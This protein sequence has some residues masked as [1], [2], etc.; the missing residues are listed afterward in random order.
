[1]YIYI[2]IRLIG[3]WFIIRRQSLTQQNA[4]DFQHCKFY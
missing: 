3:S 2:Y 4:N 1:M